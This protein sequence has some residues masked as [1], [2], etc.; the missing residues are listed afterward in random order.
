MQMS[1]KLTLILFSI[2]LLY[3]FASAGKSGQNKK[4][5][6][7]CCEEKKLENEGKKAREPLCNTIKT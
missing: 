7:L 5:K 4:K 1:Q 2:F 3:I 6:L